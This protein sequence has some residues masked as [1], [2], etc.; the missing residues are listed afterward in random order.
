[1]DGSP[2]TIVDRLYQNF[3]DL[4]SALDNAGEVSLRTVADENF[5][6]SLLLAVASY[7]ERRMTETVLTFVKGR[8]E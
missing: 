4:L 5:R 1:M 6:K 8:D 7:F 3:A 2:I